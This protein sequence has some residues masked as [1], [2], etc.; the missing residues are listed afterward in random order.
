MIS[1]FFTV[2]KP[3]GMM[4]QQLLESKWPVKCEFFVSLWFRRYQLSL[5][6]VGQ[7]WRKAAL[8]FIYFSHGIYT[9]NML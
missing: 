4:L 3:A 7:S 9:E 1:H 8:P 6:A 5:Q 2:P